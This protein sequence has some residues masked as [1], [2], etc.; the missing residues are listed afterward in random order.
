MRLSPSFL[1][2]SAV[3]RA[4]EKDAEQR[5]DQNNSK[6]TTQPISDFQDQLE[7]IS[8]NNP[9]INSSLST[10]GSGAELT[11]IQQTKNDNIPEEITSASIK[12][13][14]AKW[15]RR[16]RFFMVFQIN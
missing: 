12:A 2:S 3:N 1:A 16:P 9:Q 10:A 6:S 7:N 4:F 14:I 5:V 11:A 13:N 8:P 15:F